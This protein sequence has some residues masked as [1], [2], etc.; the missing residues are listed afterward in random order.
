[1]NRQQEYAYFPYAYKVMVP[2][3]LLV[4][5]TDIIIGYY[6]YSS[7]IQSMSR[8]N[9]V[10]IMRT[11]EQIRDNTEHQLRD[12]QKVSD[13]IFND[14]DLQR[15]LQ[16]KEDS[17]QIYELTEGYVRPTLSQAT[18]L[19]AND[20]ILSLYINNKEYKESYSYSDEEARDPFYLRSY[21]NLYYTDRIN[22]EPWL[23][24]MERGTRRDGWA[25][26]GSDSMY[27]NITLARQYISFDNYEQIGYILVKA[28]LRDLFQSI[29]S[30]KLTEGADVL[31]VDGD[32][33]QVIYSRSKR[34]EKSWNEA[35]AGKDHLVESLSLPGTAW[36]VKALIPHAELRREADKI[37]GVTLLVCLTSFLLAALIGFFVSRFFSKRVRSIIRMV[38]SFHNGEFKKRT[39]TAG[40]DEFAF[41]SKAFHRMADNI[42]ELIQDVYVRS[43]QTKQAELTALQAQINPHFLYNTLSSISSMAKLG[44]VDKLAE[45]VSG[46]AQF[47]RLTLNNGSM[48]ITIGRELEQVQTYARI[49]QVKYGNRFSFLCEV[50]PSIV[51]LDTIKLILQPFVEN[52]LK[53]AWF[54]DR[55]TIRIE[56]YREDGVIVLKVIDDGV[57]FRMKKDWDRVSAA[58]RDGGGYGVANVDERIKLQFGPEYGVSL[59]SRPGM[60][61]T[62]MIVIPEYQHE[63]PGS[64]PLRQGD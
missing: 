32:N 40:N 21:Y 61:T 9:S 4:L 8:T 45:M 46:L 31:V 57:G 20:V 33:Q 62:V 52:A 23:Q 64:R 36:Q 39:V 1:M 29:D 24:A 26:I 54:E 6:S 60:G 50:D 22:N 14:L 37:R 7:S 28:R 2:Y 42:E 41:L 13:H 58:A 27:Q 15:L 43:V 63:A 3:L 30:F 44:E 16:S 10:N 34:A 53:H 59:F 17:Y 11:L 35:H 48:F 56:G 49:Q 5:L 51:H 25:Q 55:I 47:Y 12:Y 38:H 19:T 18:K